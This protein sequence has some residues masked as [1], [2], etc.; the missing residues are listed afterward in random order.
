MFSGLVIAVYAALGIGAYWPMVPG[1]SHRLPSQIYGDPVELVWFFGWTAHALAT[2][3][4]PFFSAAANVPY[5]VNM[6]QQ[7]F[8]PLL[9]ALFAPLTLLAGP[10]FSATLCWVAAMPL[11]AASAYAVLRRWQIWPPA[12]AVGGL[13]YGFSPYMINEGTQHLQFLFVPLPPLIL[14]CL[15][16]L[17]TRPRHPLRWGAALGALVAAQFFISSEFLAITAIV[18]VLGLVLAGAHNARVDRDCLRAIVGPALRGVGVAVGT[19][20]ALLA[21]P[22]WFQFD[23]PGHYNGP[24]WPNLYGYN[25]HLLEFVAP[26][27]NQLVHPALGAIGANFFAESYLADDAYLGFGVLAAVAVLA[28]ISR[29]SNCVRLTA[30]LGLFSAVLAF[31]PYAYVGGTQ[32]F[33]PFFYLSKLPA[34]GDIIPIRF[35]FAT[36]ACVAALLAFGLDRI[37]RGGFGGREPTVPV[38]QGVRWSAYGALAAVSLVVGVTWLPAGPLPSQYVNVL[39]STITKALPANNPVVL[40]YPYPRVGQDTA[41]LWQAGAGFSFRMVGVYAM[42]RQPNGSPAPE[43]PLLDPSAVQ[44]FLAAEGGGP[45]RISAPDLSLADL[46]GQTRDFV[47]RQHVGAVLLSLSAPNATT[48]SAMFSSALGPP[49]LTSHGFELWITAH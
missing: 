21:Y 6:A 5:G 31:G 19:A 28:W 23:G 12:A 45:N 47:V 26:T 20:G 32:A 18:S 36:A 22:I 16:K 24:P 2:A 8:A 40:T 29:R 37:A 13:A 14:A 4:N 11:S 7:T 39:P 3:H 46:A 44:L 49:S 38:Q 35:S 48:V 10:V 34:L 25:A 9:G 15:V 30:A 43:S 1:S 17:L 41:M 33:L 27:P 42:V